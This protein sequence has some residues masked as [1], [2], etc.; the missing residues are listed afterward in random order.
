MNRKRITPPLMA[1]MLAVP[2][3]TWAANDDAGAQG[4]QATPAELRE[5]ELLMKRGLEAMTLR[6]DKRNE[7]RIDA[8]VE[9][10]QKESTEVQAKSMGEIER[11]ADH[12]LAEQLNRLLE[13]DL[14]N[15]LPDDGAR[16]E[17]LSDDAQWL[18]TD[19]FHP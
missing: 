6:L 8:L 12:L 2:G 11:Q 4:P 17:L 18:L 7:A 1:L 19:D 5:Y 13:Q 16:I 3:I 10:M 14:V 15:R 9:G